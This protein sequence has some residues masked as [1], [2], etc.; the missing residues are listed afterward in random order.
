MKSIIFFLAIFMALTA[1]G[2]W[3]TETAVNTLVA[4]SE[5]GDMKSIG[6]SD[7]QTYVVFWK[8]VAAPVNYELRLQVLDA[9]GNRQLGDDGMLV[10]G[11]I[12]MSTYTVIWSVTVD[13]DD[14]LYIGATGTGDGSGHV[15]KLDINGNPLWGADGVTFSDGYLVTVLPLANGEAIVSWFASGQGLMQ[16][17]DAAGNTL[18]N[19]PQPIESGTSHTAPANLFELPEAGY[20]VVFHVLS[21]GISSTLYAQRY[22]ENGVAQWAVPTKLSNKTTAYNAFYSGT[23]DG[24]VVYF[25]YFASSGSRFDSFVQRINPDG[26]LPWGINGMDFDTN[27]TDY[28]MDTQIAIAPGSQYIWAV[29]TYTNTSQGQRGEYVQ[30]FDKNTGARQFTDNAKIVYPISEDFRQH[31]GPMFLMNDQPLFL[32]KKGYDN[33]VTPTTLDGVLL[34]ENGDFAWEEV[35]RPMATY[36]AAKSRIQFNRPANGQAVAVFIEDKSGGAR[37]YAQNVVVDVVPAPLD[38][39]TLVYPPDESVEIPMMVTFIWNAVQNAETY[40]IQISTDDAFENLIADEGNLVNTTYDF[41]LPDDQTTY[42]WRVKAVDATQESDWSA[43]WRFTTEIMLGVD[44]LSS[45]AELKVYPNPTRGQTFLEFNSPSACEVQLTI[46]DSKGSLVFSS[47]ERVVPGKNSFE[48][49]LAKL[50]A[51]AYHFWVKG[52]ALNLFGKFSLVR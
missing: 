49:D 7:G 18:W 35:S 43:G 31:A 20:V 30:K 5:G 21:F 2:Q 45:A 47:V 33:S 25:G 4:T 9:S 23:Q 12:S 10:S 44:L 32:L 51:D 39:P 27:E 8:T 13:K 52:K 28:E 22:D 1:H 40:Q 42:H 38:Q 37:I 17:Y 29:C 36:Q 11:N 50:P 16:R 3:T 46:Y 48:A 14:N 41:S 34:D 15:F 24:E 6:T 19:D 26:T